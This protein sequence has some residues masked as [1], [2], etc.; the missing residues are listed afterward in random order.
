MT[1]EAIYETY[2]PKVY[3]LCMGYVA[4]EAMAED[5]TQEI[6]ISVWKHLPSLQNK[7]AAGTWIFRIA[8]NHCL[9]T[10][11]RKKRKEHYPAQLPEMTATAHSDKEEKLQLLYRSIAQLEETDRIIISLVLEDL[12]QAE[13]ASITG[14]SEGNLR[15]RIHRIKERLSKKVREHGRL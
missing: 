10:V 9:Q 1:F 8:T 4:D 5:M 7:A 15:V 12:P 3:R 13:I 6:F 14:L 11:T 2:R